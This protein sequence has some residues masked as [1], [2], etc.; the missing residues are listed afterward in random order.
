[1]GRERAPF[2]LPFLPPPSPSR[3]K[4]K[5]ISG[6]FYVACLSL[7]FPIP[8]PYSPFLP[9]PYPFRRLLHRLFF[10]SLY[11]CGMIV[12]RTR[13]I[14]VEVTHG[15]S[16][17]VT[18][19]GQAR[20]GSARLLFLA[21]SRLSDSGKTRKCKVRDLHFLN[22][23][24]PDYLGAWNRVICYKHGNNLGNYI[25]DRQAPSRPDKAGQPDYQGWLT[26]YK[27]AS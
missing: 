7:S 15:Y 23:R 25:L 21:C 13:A 3:L 1:M 12:V 5:R 10:V 22:P 18:R 14:S 26:S 17:P 27:T 2:L 20:S 9:I 16:S 6:F 19:A 8:F 11:F 24:G 4:K